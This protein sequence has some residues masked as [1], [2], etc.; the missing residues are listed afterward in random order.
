MADTVVQAHQ[1]YI[2]Q[3]EA[4]HRQAKAVIQ[5]LRETGLVSEADK[6]QREY[7]LIIDLGFTGMRGRAG[8]YCEHRSTL[9][10]PVL[11]ENCPAC[12]GEV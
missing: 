12:Q 4:D 2:Q 3:A 7:L 9:R 11:R 1:A 10:L 6:A 8:L 5:G